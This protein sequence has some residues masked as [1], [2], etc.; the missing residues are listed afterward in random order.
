LY[1]H[2]VGCGT[3]VSAASLSTSH[4]VCPNCGEPVTTPLSFFS[5]M[6][7]RYRRPAAATAAESPRREPALVGA[8]TGPDAFDSD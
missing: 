5:S 2:C 3:S 7:S 8:S 6:P 4:P 1:L